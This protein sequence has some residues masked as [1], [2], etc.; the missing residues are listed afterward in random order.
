MV[1]HLSYVEG[2]YGVTFNDV[3]KDSVCYTTTSLFVTDLAWFFLPGTGSKSRGLSRR[4]MLGLG[5]LSSQDGVS[6]QE[7]AA[8]LSIP[9]LNRLIESP[10]T[11][12][13]GIVSR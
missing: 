12:A 8:P 7:E 6:H 2:G 9:Q 13:C 4:S 11:H 10:Q 1:L 3:T 5:G